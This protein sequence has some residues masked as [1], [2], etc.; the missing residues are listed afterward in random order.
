[1]NPYVTP[2]SARRD[3]PGYRAM[4]ARWHDRTS[5]YGPGFTLV[6]EPLARAAGTSR[7]AAAW[8]FKTLAA[9]SALAAAALAARLT[10]RR[11]LAAALVGW[12]RVLAVHLGGGGHND[13][14]IGA[15]I[16]AALALAAA[17]CWNRAGALWALAVAVKWVP[18]AFLVLWSLAARARRERLGL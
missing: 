5:L 12:N 16:L 14:W 8:E 15:L 3:D 9:I 7:D 18:L 13:G 4:G 17:R 6:S 11:A 1:D 10:R 2:P